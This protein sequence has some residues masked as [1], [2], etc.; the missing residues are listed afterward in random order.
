MRTNILALHTWTLD[1]T[2][3][4]Q[5]LSLARST[6]WQAVELRRVDF[7]RARK[8]GLDDAAAIASVR[9]S[10]LPVACLG[11]QMGW[12][13]CPD[14]A[15][16]ELRTLFV[17][18][19]RL[20]SALGCTR[21][22]SASDRGRGPAALAVA[23]IREFAGIAADAGLR[24]CLEFNS[25]VEQVNALPVARDLVGAA[26]HPGCGL[27]LDTYHLQ[28]SGATPADVATLEAGEIGYVQFSDV[29]HD[30]PRAEYGVDRLPPGQ[31]CV[32]F[33]EMFAAILGTGYSGPLSYEAPNPRAWERPPA[34]VLVEALAATRRLLLPLA[35]S[36]R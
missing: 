10:G 6:G 24:L 7:L 31:G 20:A 32:P 26:A 17:E 1:T 2:P 14:D 8:A 11:V 4:P 15:Y 36:A 16:R 3:L 22:M 23:R 5:V 29:P 9:D 12:L 35:R 33:R 13:F 25:G 18:S 30:G 28:R 19:C 21:L 27:L 34:D